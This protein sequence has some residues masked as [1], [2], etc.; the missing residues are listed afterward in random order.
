MKNELERMKEKGIIEEITEPTDWCAKMVPVVKK[1]G[2][3]RICTDL[4]KLYLSV[5]RERYMMPTLE[6]VLQKLKVDF[7]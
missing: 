6:D 7:G 2:E 5:K 3:V 4:K 1:S